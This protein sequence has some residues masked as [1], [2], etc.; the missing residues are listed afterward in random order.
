MNV[1]QCVLV[2]RKLIYFGIARRIASGAYYEAHQ[3]LRVIAARYIK[4]ANYDAA[5]DLLAGGATAL[6]K[7]GSQQGA[8][9]SGGDLAIMLVAEVYNKAGWEITGGNDDTEGRSRKSEF[10]R[11]DSYYQKRAI[12]CLYCFK[13]LQNVSSNC[14]AN[15]PPRSPRGNGSFRK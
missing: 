14:C 2:P 1:I 4:Q 9:A 3:Q 12:D 13:P 11:N 5:A 10:N 7:A 15:S 6:L 8:S